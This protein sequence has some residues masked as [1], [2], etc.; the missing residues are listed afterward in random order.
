MNSMQTLFSWL[1]WISRKIQL[2]EEKKLGYFP[3]IP[4]RVPKVIGFSFGIEGHPKLGIDKPSA[5][6]LAFDRLIATIRIQPLL[7]ALFFTWSC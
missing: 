6:T 2:S 1:K 5:N 7:L 3:S 4:K